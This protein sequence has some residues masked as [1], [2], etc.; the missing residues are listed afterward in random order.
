MPSGQACFKLGPDVVIQPLGGA[1]QET[2]ALS[3]RSGYLYT[4]NPVAASF[5]AALDGQTPYAKVVD[6]LLEEYEVGREQLEA[7]LAELVDELTREEL[8][9][10]GP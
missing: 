8:I 10:A 4:C 2:V 6:H 9:V 7:D 5:L 1:D 3:L